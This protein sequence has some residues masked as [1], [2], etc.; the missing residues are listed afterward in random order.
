MI[1]VHVAFIRR[2]FVFIYTLLYVPIP[3]FFYF[4]FL[5]IVMCVHIITPQFKWH[6][7]VLHTILIRNLVCGWFKLATFVWIFNVNEIKKKNS[8]KMAVFL[9]GET[10]SCDFIFFSV[11]IRFCFVNNEFQKI[12]YLR[13]VICCNNR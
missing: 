7:N 4:T 1:S 11:F 9:F 10:D 5:F 2:P 3:N 8:N 6:L 13:M 12:N